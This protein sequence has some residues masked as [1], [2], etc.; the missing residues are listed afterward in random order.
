MLNANYPTAAKA[1]KA[2]DSKGKGLWNA[3]HSFAQEIASLGVES[4]R[5]KFKEQEKLAAD[6]VKVAMTKNSTYKVAK[7][8][9]IKAIELGISLVDAK[10]KPKGK[11]A[12][13][14]EIKALDGGKGGAEEPEEEKSNLT[15]AQQFA[16]LVLAAGRL[17]P[18]LQDADI[19]TA[20][21]MVSDLYGQVASRLPLLKAA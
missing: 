11:T 20:A 13:E 8:K 19:Q 6:H 3:L 7:G 21:S 2:I 14:E 17:V 16:E 15:P 5:E 10:G 12:I 1:V 9:L 4:V 18:T